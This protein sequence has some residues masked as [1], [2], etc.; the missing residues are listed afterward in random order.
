[1][2]GNPRIPAVKPLLKQGR[3]NLGKTKLAI[4]LPIV[5]VL[6]TV[7]LTNW[8]EAIQLR[9]GLLNSHVGS[10]KY[11][12]L[13]LN[14]PGLVFR[15]TEILISPIKGIS[16]GLAFLLDT[17]L[18]LLGVALLW[19]YVGRQIDRFVSGTPPYRW[20]IPVL[21]FLFYLFVILWGLKLFF[22]GNARFYTSDSQNYH[23]PADTTNGVIFIIWSMV[24]IIFGARKIVASASANAKSST[25]STAVGM[26]PAG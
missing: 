17:V 25:G 8:G 26:G 22:L 14:G 7:V 6:L 23:S 5:Q 15:Y 9:F 12:C 2:R 3:S 18:Y 13:A 21:G 4:L 24:L 20:R 11:L 16:H 19:Y 10:V 1:V